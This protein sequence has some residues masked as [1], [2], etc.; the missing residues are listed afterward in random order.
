MATVSKVLGRVLDDSELEFVNGASDDE[1]VVRRTFAPIFQILMRQ[2]SA[3]QSTS[4]GGSSGGGSSALK[5]SM[6]PCTLTF[7]H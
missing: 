4:T 3:S 1:S 6:N 2:R 7:F 5:A